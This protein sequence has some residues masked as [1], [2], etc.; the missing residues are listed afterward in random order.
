MG[1]RCYSKSNHFGYRSASHVLPNHIKEERGRCGMIA[2]HWGRLVSGLKN[3]PLGDLEKIKSTLAAALW[4]VHVR[5]CFYPQWELWWC[6]TRAWGKH[7]WSGKYLVGVLLHILYLYTPKI[8][9]IGFFIFFPSI[10]FW[11]YTLITV[12]SQPHTSS[13]FL[14]GFYVMNRYKTA[15]KAEAY[16][17]FEIFYKYNFKNCAMQLYTAPFTLIVLNKIQQHVASRSRHIF[18]WATSV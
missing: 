15:V 18:K 9:R 11:F 8:K 1:F 10:E 7:N 3:A 6:C 16:M 17:N 4:Y 2:D 14:L 12:V 13:F 5:M